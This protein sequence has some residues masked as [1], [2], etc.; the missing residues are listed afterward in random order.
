V[1]ATAVNREAGRSVSGG[2]L[3]AESLGEAVAAAGGTVLA[4]SL[5]ALNWFG[6]A[7][8]HGAFAPRAAP[9]AA[10]TGWDVLTS[11]RWLL[12][13]SALAA[14]MALLGTLALRAGLAAG[15]PPAGAPPTSRSLAPRIVLRAAGGAVAALGTLSAALL[16]YR[17]LIV[18]PGGGSISDQKL[19]ALLGLLGALGVALGGWW[20]VRR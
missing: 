4:V 6:F 7:G 5:V 17:V 16:V 2:A 1:S 12:L 11:L 10:A 18:L 20:S 15:P 14:W 9:V 19:G 8:A 3:L 13:A